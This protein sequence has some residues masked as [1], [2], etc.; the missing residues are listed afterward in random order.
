MEPNVRE[1][2]SRRRL[3]SR[4][5]YLLIV[6]VILPSSLKWKPPILLQLNSTV[7]MCVSSRGHG[8][9]ALERLASQKRPLSN[10]WL[11]FHALGTLAALKDMMFCGPFKLRPI[12]GFAC[13]LWDCCYQTTWA[14]QVNVG[15]PLSGDGD[16]PLQAADQA[17][18]RGHLLCRPELLPPAAVQSDEPRSRD[19][20]ISIIDHIQHHS[21]STSQNTTLPEIVRSRTWLNALAGQSSPLHPIPCSHSVIIYCLS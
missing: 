15:G 14:L 10:Q 5:C 9:R 17:R 4:I 18:G 11:G 1:M 3:L 19:W 21:R 7:I 13:G 6:Q 8:L 12:R 2:R 20:F 16:P